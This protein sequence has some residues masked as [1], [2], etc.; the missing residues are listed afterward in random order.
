MFKRRKREDRLASLVDA[1]SRGQPF[2]V[3]YNESLSSALES[4]LMA[5]WRRQEWQKAQLA[6]ERNRSAALIADIAHQCRT[7]L[8]N[9][10]LYS[11]LL[12]EAPLAEEQA[13][14]VDAL[15]VQT[16]KLTFLLDALLKGARLEAGL[17]TTKPE[18]A[19]LFPLVRQ[20]VSAA[21]PAAREKG[22]RIKVEAPEA[23]ACY[24]LKWTAEAL[25]NVLDNAVKYAPAESDIQVRVAPLSFYTRIDVADEGPGIV[26]GEEAY[27]FNR[28]YRSAH[29]HQ[30]S[31]VGL[32]L[33]LAREILAAQKGYITVKNVPG[34]CFSLYL[35]NQAESV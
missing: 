33:Y 34:A 10:Q 29:V 35:P 20:A 5:I 19:A 4:R 30:V 23:F 24:D 2:S 27:I 9:L 22:I 7:P 25:G 11:D 3:T 12:S 13:A 8:A 17:M 26:P 1:I 15:L 32:G 14:Q 6:E 21:Q 31:G 28:F 18:R 16:E